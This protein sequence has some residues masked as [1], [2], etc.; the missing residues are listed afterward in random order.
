MSILYK[1]LLGLAGIVFPVSLFLNTQNEHQPITTS[2]DTASE[3]P[4]LQETVQSIT[5]TS[6]TVKGV[7][8]VELYAIASVVDGDTIKVRMND[9][10]ETIRLIGIDTPETVHPSKPVQCFGREASN[11]TKGLLT[12]KKVRVEKDESQGERDKYGRLLAYVFLEN[13]TNVNTALISDGF[14]YEYTYNVPYKYQ[15][16]FKKAESDAKLNKR[17][18]WADGICSETKDAVIVPS[19]PIKAI[20]PQTSS[21]CDSNYS[22]TCVPIAS[23]VDCAGGTGNGPAYVSGPV[24]IVGSDIYKLDSDGDGV[25]C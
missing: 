21:P 13:G 10:I 7:P 2:T 8:N 6:S 23:D 3:I 12:G 1:T 4:A 16:E 25:A 17:G 22:G 18:L 11:K 9:K 20:A 5:D 14:A 15:S 19:V 24:Y